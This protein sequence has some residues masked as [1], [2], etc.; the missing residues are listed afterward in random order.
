M[1]K[2]LTFILLIFFLVGCSQYSYSPPKDKSC[3]YSSKKLCESKGCIWKTLS[4][5]SENPMP[6]TCCTKQE[7]D[8]LRKMTSKEY[9]Y[10]QRDP[11]TILPG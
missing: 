9:V 6:A 2:K 11:C 3:D 1:I 5:V 8:N 4:D 10:D 7:I